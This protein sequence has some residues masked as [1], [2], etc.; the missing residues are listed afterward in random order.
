MRFKFV[1]LLVLITI[2]LFLSIETPVQGSRP[3]Q[4]LLQETYPIESSIPGA[5]LEVS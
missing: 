3:P 2:L 4:S 5:A 1:S